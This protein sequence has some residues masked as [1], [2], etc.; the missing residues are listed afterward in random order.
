MQSAHQEVEEVQCQATSNHN[1]L[2]KAREEVQDLKA[3]L[4]VILMESQD[5]K[6]KGNSLFAE[7][8]DRRIEAEKTLI[9]L[10]VQHSSLQ[11]RYVNV[12]F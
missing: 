11:Q 2:E 12:K 10:K 9:S 8:E 5:M 3:Q 7:V 6:K 4:D 1:A